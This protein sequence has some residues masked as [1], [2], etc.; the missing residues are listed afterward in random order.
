MIISSMILGGKDEIFLKPSLDSVDD[1]CD[2][3]IINDNS[4]VTNENNLK[5][6]KSS[7]PYKNNKIVIIKNLFDGFDNARNQIL[8]YI[9][10]KKYN[11]SWIIKLDADEVHGKNLS[12]ITRNII[13]ALPDDYSVVDVYFYQFLQSFSYLRSI[14]RRHNF[15]VRFNKDMLWRGRVHEKI[16]NV[17]GRTLILP[18][19]FYHY[20]CNFAPSEILN[21]WKLYKSLGDSNQPDL[22]EYNNDDFILSELNS[23]FSF[24]GRHPAH[25]KD[26]INEIIKNR[27]NEIM[28][29]ESIISEINKNKRHSLH[30]YINKY[31]FLF[32]IFYRRVENYI[33][34]YFNKDIKNGLKELNKNDN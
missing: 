6:I 10:K 31:N 23:C 8:D 12:I 26:V 4:Y 18:Y 17:I 25:M 5:Y 30:N 9:K 19:I 7:I 24:N 20:G 13:P 1:A 22:D 34:Y 15:L 28:R 11:N 14:D 21:K 32:R 33:K 2:L 27:G 16:E 3:I 29:Y